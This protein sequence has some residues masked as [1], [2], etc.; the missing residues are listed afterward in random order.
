MTDPR[1]K[2]TAALF[3]LLGKR[4]SSVMFMRVSSVAHLRVHFTSARFCIRSSLHPLF[5]DLLNIFREINPPKIL[6]AKNSRDP[7]SNNFILI[8]TEIHQQE[9][10]TESERLVPR[11]TIFFFTGITQFCEHQ[12]LLK[13][14]GNNISACCTEGYCEEKRKAHIWKCFKK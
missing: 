11:L 9:R 8:L 5:L 4:T 12:L 6:S 10:D 2:E 14:E 7:A 1:K 13:H 3:C